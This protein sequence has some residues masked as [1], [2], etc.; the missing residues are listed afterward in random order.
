M[1]QFGPA[2]GSGVDLRALFPN[3][4][5]INGD[6]IK[7][8]SVTADSRRCQ[9]GDVFVAICGTEQDGHQFVGEALDQGASA[10]I[11]ERLVP[12]RDVPLCIVRDSR[13]AF[14]KLCHELVDRPSERLKVIGVTGTN[15]KTTTACLIHSLFSVAGYQSGIMGTLGYCDGIRT[16]PSPLTTPS[17]ATLAHTMQR[18]VSNGCSHAVLELSSH[19]LAQRRTSGLELDVACLTNVGHDHLDFHGSQENYWKA[20]ARIFRHLR[21][22]GV[23]ILNLDDPP[24]RKYLRHL[25]GPVLTIGMHRE[26]ELNATVIERFASEQT[27]LLRCGSDLIPVRTR[28]IGDH[29]VYNCLSAAA[30]GLTH[31]IDLPTVVRGLEA[32]DEMPG[33]MQRIEFGQ[34]FSVFIDYAHTPDALRA[35][36]ST[37]KDV[38]DR[39]VI[40]VFGAGGQRDKE[41]RPV[42]GRIVSELADTA[43]I[44]ND[45]PRQESADAIVLGILGG[46]D[47]DACEIIVE[48]DRAAAIDAALS[49]AKEGDCVVIA[50]KGHETYQLIGDERIYF[51]DREV[52]RSWLRGALRTTDATSTRRAA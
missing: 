40:C 32:I 8:S 13:M 49:S 45:N 29:H 44:T 30:V 46:A 18:M 1:N 24:S 35:C 11:A 43:V 2:T 3:A 25:D 28:I 14:G 16:A 52:V 26:A 22:E 15:G 4:R 5:F 37:L 20:K 39:R 38:C 6:Y 12:T 41:K 36:L 27:F 19:A 31:G 17:A 50:G 9:P 23:S 7:C 51:D 42:M 10:V 34:P 33:R 21:A 47:R 48:T